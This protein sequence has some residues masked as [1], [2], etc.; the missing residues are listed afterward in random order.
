MFSGNISSFGDINVNSL[1]EADLMTDYLLVSRSQNFTREV[2]M[3]NI[4][5]SNVSVGGKV[6]GYYLPDEVRTTMKVFSVV[7]YKL[8][9]KY[10]HEDAEKFVHYCF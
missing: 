1:N 9:F 8:W 4:I 7:L 5:T 2:T 10:L 3:N 6:N